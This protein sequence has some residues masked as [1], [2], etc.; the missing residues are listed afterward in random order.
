MMTPTAAKN[1]FTTSESILLNIEQPMNG[2]IATK[3]EE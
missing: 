3:A 1:S 2:A